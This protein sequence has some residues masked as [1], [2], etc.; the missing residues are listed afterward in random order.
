MSQNNRQ[1]ENWCYLACLME[2]TARK[3]GNV[4]PEASF[5]DL[6]Y[7][8]FVKSAQVTAPLLVQSQPGN[9]G[10]VVL[11]CVKETRKVTSSNS[12]LGMIL[13]LAPLLAVPQELTIT[14][15]I[16]AIL[17]GLTVDDAR[18]VYTA[19]RLAQAGG[20]GKTEAEDIATDPTG[21][22]REVMRLAA[23]RDAIASEYES[24]FQIILQTAVPA[25]KEFWIQT[26]DWEA[27]IIRLQ[28]QLMANYPDTLI[29]R[30]CGRSE[31]EQA[32][33][34]ARIVLQSA[35]FKTSLAELDNWLR[36]TGNRRNPGTTADLIAA[37]LFVALRDGF[38]PTPEVS[39]ITEKVPPRFKPELRILAHEG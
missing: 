18:S 20:L 13:L 29:A 4:H 31:A 21:T 16:D 27:A 17:T 32:A 35:D 34:R 3:P 22:L 30:K 7:I 26:L 14:E 36:A 25:L 39:T 2:A 15:G 12:N 38:I 11:N 8:D 1:L 33:E 28:L 5:P 23:D 19:I 6:S 10:Q 9:V 37:A 24:G